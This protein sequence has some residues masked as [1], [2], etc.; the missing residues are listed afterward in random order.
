MSYKT[1]FDNM[2]HLKLI[3]FLI[4]SISLTQC[5][6]EEDTEDNNEVITLEGDY[7]GTW[8]S[9]TENSLFPGTIISTKLRFLNGNENK[10]VGEFFVSG[11]FTSCCNSGPNDGTLSM[12]VDGDMITSFT[13]N[14]IIPD[15]GGTFNGTGEVRT[16][17]ELFINFTGQDC[18]GNHVGT[19]ILRP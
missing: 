8:A 1:K 13:Y 14:D 6:T 3:A 2:Y 7:T 17:E 4:L 18:D 19:I 11:N 5:G 15:C 10:L 9:M 12:D 16:N